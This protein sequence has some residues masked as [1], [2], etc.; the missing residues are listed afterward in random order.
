MHELSLAVG[1]L[2]IARDELARHDCTRLKLLRV[3]IG[4]ISGV[5][6]EALR[7]GF[8]ALVKG[9][10][11][12]GARLDIVRVPLRLRCGSCG[13]VFE[14]EDAVGAL[15]PCPSCGE[16]FGHIVLDGKQM[17]ITWLEGE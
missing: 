3:E 12:E 1:M 4:A 16:V 8:A 15:T 14:G 13:T 7:F 10:V 9:S 6:P 11:H 2:D 5:V 17:R